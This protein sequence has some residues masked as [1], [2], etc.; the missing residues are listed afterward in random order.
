MI[1]RPII[2][3]IS[4]VMSWRNEYIHPVYIAHTYTHS[5]T[6][7]TDKLL[8][9]FAKIGDFGQRFVLSTFLQQ[10]GNSTA[11]FAILFNTQQWELHGALPSKVI[12]V[13]YFKN[14]P[15]LDFSCSSKILNRGLNHGLFI[16]TQVCGSIHSNKL[17]W[18][19]MIKF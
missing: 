5:S 8:I 4:A 13:K 7:L 9:L 17:N 16:S 10:S 6:Y 18:K 12:Y 3:C 2:V 19:F 11:D 15:Y 14:W 1:L